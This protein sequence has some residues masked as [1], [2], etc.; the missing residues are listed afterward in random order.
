MLN[1]NKNVFL[2]SLFLFSAN[3]FFTFFNIFEIYFHYFCFLVSCGLLF[4]IVKNKYYYASLC[5]FVV[6][7]MYFYSILMNVYREDLMPFLLEGTNLAPIWLTQSTSENVLKLHSNFLTLVFL[8]IQ[9]LYINSGRHFF[10]SSKIN[11]ARTIFVLLVFANIL[12]FLNPRPPLIFGIG[13]FSNAYINHYEVPSAGIDVLMICLFLLSVFFTFASYF[14][15]KKFYLI[16]FLI[17]LNVCFFTLFRGT[18]S[19]IIVFM[20]GIPVLYYLF[21]TSKYKTLRIFLI[22]FAMFLLLQFWAAYR[23]NVGNESNV[24]AITTSIN[25]LL[26]AGTHNDDWKEYLISMERFP[27]LYWNVLVVDTLLND[28]VTIGLTSFF[29]LAGQ[30]VPS[31]LADLIDYQRPP[32]GAWLLA[33]H[34]EHGGAMY[35]LA[36]AYWNLSGYGLYIF[37][38]IFIYTTLFIEKFFNKYLAGELGSYKNLLKGSLYFVYFS[39]PITLYGSMSTFI[40]MLEI[41]ALLSMLTFIIIND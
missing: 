9:P 25:D 2:L 5:I 16:L 41:L 26:F 32:D 27:Q 18:R 29:N 8:F 12:G 28:N 20:L 30:A 24:A 39:L 36:E 33:D 23:W 22:P 40:K 37:G 13:Y 15:S 34:V 10:V 17:V 1:F 7:A 3:I 4:L 35:A 19:A 31:F 11:Y 14:G 6:M 38:F 21:S